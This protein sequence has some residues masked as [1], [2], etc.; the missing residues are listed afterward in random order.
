[1]EEINNVT[2]RR[3]QTAVS[4]SMD[5][6]DQSNNSPIISC[7]ELLGRSLDLSTNISS[8]YIAEMKDEIKQLKSNLESTQSE[9]ENIILENLELKKT[10]A[11]MNQEL[12]ILKQ[13]CR[14]PLTTFNQ[15]MSSST[16]KSVRRRLTDSFRV[17]PQKL[18]ESPILLQQLNKEVTSESS[19]RTRL[20]ENTCEGRSTASQADTDTKETRTT[21]NTENV[22]LNSKHKCNKRAF[23]IGGSQCSGLSSRLTK[24]RFSNP[25]NTYQFNSII[26]TNASTQEILTSAKLF[27]IKADDKLIISIGQNDDNTLKMTT[28]LCLFLKTVP[29]PVIVL[30]VNKNIYSNELKLN[31]MLDLICSQ[32]KECYF[33]KKIYNLSSLCHKIN[34]LLD[35][36]DYNKQFLPFY[37]SSSNYYNNKTGLVSSVNILKTKNQSTQTG[38][39]ILIGKMNKSSD[40]TDLSQGS[41]LIQVENK[42]FFRT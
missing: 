38:D 8:T 22:I 30:C 11:N 35:Q 29:C 3:H 23:I 37:G 17:T 2:L 18:N 15:N 36:L 41:K 7:D 27:D 33:L 31:G 1:M 9:M 5:F 42:S 40:I 10:I 28:E 16:K 21:S 25:Y 6:L 14:S 12:G 24:S 19:K 26:K 13:L 4:R 32:S 39:D 20:R 34:S